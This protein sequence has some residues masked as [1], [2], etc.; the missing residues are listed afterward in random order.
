MGV[1][2][3]GDEENQDLGM[4]MYENGFAAFG[5][6]TTMEASFSVV[7]ISMVGLGSMC[8]AKLGEA[9]A[10]VWSIMPAAASYKQQSIIIC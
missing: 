4:D 2:F 7:T 10:Q 5:P 8:W 3:V 6:W 1:R 9:N